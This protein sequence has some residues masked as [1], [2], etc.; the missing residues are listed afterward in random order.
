MKNLSQLTFD[1][2]LALVT[3]SCV[4]TRET[5]RTTSIK[6]AASAAF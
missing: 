1:G 3:S 6:K 4:V 2:S 5:E